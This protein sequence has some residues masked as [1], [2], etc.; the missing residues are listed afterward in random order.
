RCPGSGV[1]GPGPLPH[2]RRRMRCHPSAMRTLRTAG[3]TVAVATLTAGLLLTAPGSA[4]GE[5]DR[6]HAVCKSRACLLLLDSRQDKDGDG[7][8]DVD[9]AVLYTDPGD[10]LSVPDTAKL[11]DM[12]LARELPSFE[13]HLTELVMLPTLTPDGSA[14]AT[15][16]G[17]FN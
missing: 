12:L 10:K 8:A 16:L 4:A 14:I 5:A 17:E 2:S 7:V 13:K 3:A 9:E 15:G 11:L 6:D 1:S